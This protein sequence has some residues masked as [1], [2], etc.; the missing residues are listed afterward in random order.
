MADA[1]RPTDTQTGKTKPADAYNPVN[2][3]G[4]KAAILEEHAKQES[5]ENGE[6]AKPVDDTHVRPEQSRKGS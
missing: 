5:K 4:K 3:A 1:K 6:P 2:M